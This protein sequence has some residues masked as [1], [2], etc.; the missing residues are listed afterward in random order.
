MGQLLSGLV[1]TGSLAC[2]DE[3]DRIEV[4]V[5]SVIAQQLLTIQ[6][7]I[8]Q[9]VHFFIFEG[10]NIKLNPHC[11]FFIT[12]NPGYSGRT[13]LP[14]NLKALFRPVAMTMPDSELIS[15]IL[16][17]SEGFTKSKVIF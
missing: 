15:E 8:Q 13:E 14:E 6:T 10:R 7:A 5:L 3:L 4:E 2:F 11:G 16:L 9:K 17:F 12:M 1:Q